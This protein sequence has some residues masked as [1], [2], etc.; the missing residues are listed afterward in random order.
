MVGSITGDGKLPGLLGRCHGNLDPHGHAAQP[1]GHLQ[2]QISRLSRHR[3]WSET[4][5]PLQGSTAGQGWLLHTSA[6]E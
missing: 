5:L 2:Q 6:A 1:G 3:C 4:L